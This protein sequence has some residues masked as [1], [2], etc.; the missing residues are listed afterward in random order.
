MWC[1]GDAAQ[2]KLVKAGVIS[3]QYNKVH[4]PKISNQRHE[5]KGWFKQLG[6]HVSEIFQTERS[7][8]AVLQ[9]L[10]W[11]VVSMKAFHGSSCLWNDDAVNRLI[12]QSCEHHKLHNYFPPQRSV[13]ET[14]ILETNVSKPPQKTQKRLENS[15]YSCAWCHLLTSAHSHSPRKPESDLPSP[16][17]STFPSPKRKGIRSQ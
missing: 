7:L 8:S 10:W 3:T 17:D 14:E 9:G 4:S 11:Q 5:R 12:S 16:P 15:T 6:I 2:A 1:I 13:A